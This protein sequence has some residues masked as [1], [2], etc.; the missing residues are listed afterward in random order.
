MRVR[1]TAAGR[2]IGAGDLNPLAPTSSQPPADARPP[3]RLVGA[4]QRP[5]WRP[6]PLGA[7]VG[8]P[9][10]GCAAVTGVAHTRAVSRDAEHPEVNQPSADG[11]EFEADNP[12]PAPSAPVPSLRPRPAAARLPP[13]DLPPG[14]L[15]EID[16]I[17]EIIGP[18]NSRIS[19][20]SEIGKSFAIT[21]DFLPKVDPAWFGV[22]QMVRDV[23][24]SSALTAALS[25][26]FAAGELARMFAQPAWAESALSASAFL[27][28]HRLQVMDFSAHIE[29]IIPKF[30]SVFVLPEIGRSLTLANEAWALV[31]RLTP[32]VPEVGA[33]W[34]LSEAGR[35]TLG[36]SA[37]GLLLNPSDED[38][39]VDLVDEDEDELIAGPADAG[40]RLR[41][42]LRRLN[43]RLVDRLDG[44][45][46][47]VGRQG[48]DA[49]SQAAN[50]LVELIDW[51]L[52][53][54]APDAAVLSWHAAESRPGDELNQGRP[55]RALRIRFVVRARPDALAA[56]MYVSS[57]RELMK[58]LQA[59]K[60]AAGEQQLA[61]V[62]RLVP[63]VEAF[64]SFLLL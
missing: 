15:R 50:S 6:A 24:G 39:A 16:R 21:A 30:E 22:G 37:T 57:L 2:E 36:V 63:T 25:S 18:I 45:W 23:A 4:P 29:A 9:P 62:A 55:T 46:E 10:K 3:G 28:E 41:D 60:H 43:P 53:L 1:W 13:I 44:A 34:R 51:T 47:R 42:E 35:T 26:G 19:A 64:L 7:P 33:A 5:Y 31:A 49:T 54:A 38:W 52:R 59:H 56:E 48:P 12:K 11:T 40:K 61:A 14:Y 8:G 32:E 27:A 20:I 17:R 58:L